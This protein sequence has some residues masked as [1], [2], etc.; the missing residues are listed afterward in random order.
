MPLQR[1]CWL[2]VVLL[3]VLCSCDRSDPPPPPDAFDVPHDFVT[4]PEQKPTY[5]FAP[6]LAHAHPEVVAFV[7]EFME[8]CLAGDYTGY[9]RLVTRRA[10]PESRKRFERI[11]H[12]LQSLAVES[13]RTIEL[14]EGVGTAY[15]VT[16]RAAFRP[17]DQAALRQGHE[18]R[19]AIIVL[20]EDGQWRM[21]LAPPELQPPRETPPPD[22][23]P[24]TTAPSYPWDE[25]G[26]Y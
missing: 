9:R 15:L 14:P 16:S 12:S 24:A 5:D 17:D 2:A 13:V 23:A 11:L 6:G 3:P 25:D 1:K 21:G 8:T 18:R 19:L 22:S 20:Q 7:R 10:T 26:D 4:L